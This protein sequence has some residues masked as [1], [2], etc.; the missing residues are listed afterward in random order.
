MAKRNRNE[1]PEEEVKNVDEV[2]VELTSME[3]IVEGD[4]TEKATDV[5]NG[6][7]AVIAPSEEV[8]AE[9]EN[10]K[11]ED[12]ETETPKGDA[13]EETPEGEPK[14]E[15]DELLDETDKGIIDTLSKTGERIDEILDGDPENIQKA[16]ET[17]KEK[18]E[19]IEKNLEESI[20][21][22]EKSIL[23]DIYDG[24]FG[25]YWNGVGCDY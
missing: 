7:P 14:V 24:G 8:D 4:D 21:E 19:G 20:K 11:K 5:E 12:D 13:G 18:I 16:L 17:E 6:D 3:P 15:S 22:K 10:E 25:N 1:T 2:T 9:T 23:K